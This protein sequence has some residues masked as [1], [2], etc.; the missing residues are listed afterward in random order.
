MT[1]NTI[2]SAGTP[3]SL[4]E[5]LPSAHGGSGSGAWIRDRGRG[6]GKDAGTTRRSL[7]P[8]PSWQDNST[9]LRSSKRRAPGM[10]TFP[11][12]GHAPA[13]EAGILLKSS[14]LPFARPSGPDPLPERTL[15]N[16]W[17][18]VPAFRFRAPPRTTLSRIHAVM[19]SRGAA[20]SAERRAGREQVDAGNGSPSGDRP[21]F[22]FNVH[23]PRPPRLRVNLSPVSTAWIRLSS[24]PHRPDPH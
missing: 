3:Q 9:R 12:H 6:L 20:E 24:I 7:R 16:R 11:S 18:C 21:A 22:H 14:P 8:S 23:S 19:N 15:P 1:S 5:C 13:R 10:I 2:R 4:V 17:G